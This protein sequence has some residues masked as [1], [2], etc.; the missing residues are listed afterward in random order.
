MN[1]DKLLRKIASGSKDIK[2]S[3]FVWLLEAMGFKLD[4]VSGSHHIFKHPFVR[5]I[6][7]VQNCSGQAKPYQIRQFLKL[8][9]RHGIR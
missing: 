1:K 9:E 5:E 2:F 4:R 3:E 8:I 7:N 6:I